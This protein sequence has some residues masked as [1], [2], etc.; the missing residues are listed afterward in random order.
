MEFNEIKK[1]LRPETEKLPNGFDWNSMEK[2]IKEKMRKKKKRPFLLIYFSFV[3]GLLSLVGISFLWNDYSSKST[4]DSSIN[5]NVK[6]DKT[7]GEFKE[8][9][10]AENVIV[11]NKELLLANSSSVLNS[12]NKLKSIEDKVEGIK[13]S[14]IETILEDVTTDNVNVLLPLKSLEKLQE[15]AKSKVEEVAMQSRES[16][17]IVIVNEEVN[18]II[19]PT[20][21][22]EVSIERIEPLNIVLDDKINL[23][24]EK[25]SFHA[26]IPFRLKNELSITIGTN[27][28]KWNDSSTPYAISRTEYQ[29]PL[30]SYQLNVDYKMFLNNYFFWK[31]GINIAKNEFLFDYYGETKINHLL[32]NVHYSTI[33]DTI[34]NEVT[35]LSKDTIVEATLERTVKNYNVVHNINL[36]LFIGKK[37]SKN[38]LFFETE[39]GL[40]FNF[41]TKAEGKLINPLLEIIDIS[42]TPVYKKN[43][44]IAIG[45][46]FNIG[47]QFSE[48]WNFRFG[49]NGMKLLSNRSEIEEVNLLPYSFGINSGIGFKF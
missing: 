42:D 7:K 6:V 31:T 34:T 13:V 44:G 9:S 19:L 26:K 43:V 46:G 29:K 38:N 21:F 14:Q 1:N 28:S 41:I 36:P 3:I 8:S 49:I 24:E 39:A 17:Q 5:S 12:E 32:N 33:I 22:S 18:K 4:A 2:G 47:Y 27:R 11:N 45:G 20:I 40:L 10:E 23:T 30:I 15:E 37:W 16:Q 48:K 25:I 35:A